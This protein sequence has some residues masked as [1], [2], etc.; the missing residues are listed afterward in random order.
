MQFQLS[1]YCEFKVEHAFPNQSFF[2]HRSTTTTAMCILI[3]ADIS[4][5]ISGSVTVDRRL[6]A[7]SKK[8]N[9][10]AECPYI[11]SSGVP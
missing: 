8:E 9:N 4:Y 10:T 1:H 5:F 6:N 7:A 11:F 3:Y 2:N